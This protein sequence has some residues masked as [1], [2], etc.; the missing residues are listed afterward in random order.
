MAVILWSYR[1]KFTFA[2]WFYDVSHLGR[3]RTICIPNFD[4]ISLSTTEILLFPV[5]EYKRPP[6]LN[7]TPVS[8]LISSPSSACDSAP[9]A[10]LP[11]RSATEL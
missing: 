2:F 4:Q 10:G 9:A 6:Y 8:M 11:I 7:S 5:A 3:Q 1:H